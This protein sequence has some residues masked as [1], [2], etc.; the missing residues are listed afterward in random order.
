MVVKVAINGFGRIGRIYFSGNLECLLH[1]KLSCLSKR[2]RL[3]L[4]SNSCKNS[5]SIFMKK[6]GH[7]RQIKRSCLKRT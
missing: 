3:S 7:N 2:M 4:N 1:Y 6:L 5:Y